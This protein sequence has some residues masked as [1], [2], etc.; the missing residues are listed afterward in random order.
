M[1][2]ESAGK[3]SNI[4][5][6]DGVCNLCNGTVDFLIRKDKRRLFK[7]SPLQGKTSEK[8][9]PSE[10]ANDLAGIVYYRNDKIYIKSSAALMVAKDLG[11]LY[12]LAMAFW[13]IPRFIRDGIYN[14]IARNRYRWYG[15][16]EKCRV[17]TP[18]ERNLFLD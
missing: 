5:F 15:K 14:W 17:P 11:G 12:K 1:K 10:Y 18:E 3:N 8:L 6:F 9:L 16:K 4:V 2:E 13:V 7:Y